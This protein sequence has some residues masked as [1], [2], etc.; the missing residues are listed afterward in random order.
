VPPQKLHPTENQEFRDPP[1]ARCNLG[2]PRI[3]G[4]LLK[5]GIDVSQSTVAKYCARTGTPSLELEDLPAESCENS[6]IFLNDQGEFDDQ[7]ASDC[8][9]R[10]PVFSAFE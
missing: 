1:P 8:D 3:H 7:F 10:S 9:T 2:A 5:L 4:E 6:R